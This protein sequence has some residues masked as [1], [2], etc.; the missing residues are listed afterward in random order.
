MPISLW[1][2]SHLRSS[3]PRNVLS[4]AVAASLVL[5]GCVVQ[6]V[7][8]VN[9]TVYVAPPPSYP[10]L[11]YATSPAPQRAVVS[12]YFEPPVD[13]PPPVL[14][15]WAPPPML[16]EPPSPQ[17]YP[18]A[19][20]TGGYW[21]W[22]GDWVWAAGRWSAPPRPGYHW[23]HPYY[24]HRD[25][26]VVFVSGFWASASVGFS[27]PGLDIRLTIARPLPGVVPGPPCNGPQGVF[28]PPPPGS[29]TGLIVPAPVGTPP[30]VVVSAP[31][32][33]NVGMRV[34]NNVVNNQVTN[35]TNV[36]NVTNVTVVAPAGTTASG[37]A[38]TANVP[39]QAHLAASIP[40]VTHVQAPKPMSTQAIPAFVAGR[41]QVALPAAQQ[42]RVLPSAVP[43]QLPESSGPRTQQP[44]APTV[45]PA[46]V[47]AAQPIRGNP[48]GD[49]REA[50][51][52]SGEARRSQDIQRHQQELQRSKET[53]PRAQEDQPRTLPKTSQEDE[54]LNNQQM[55]A[56]RD[57][58]QKIQQQRAD[59]D[60]QQKA[61]QV[62][63]QQ[64]AEQKTQ[65]LKA[66]RETQQKAQQLNAQQE[67]QQKAQQERER[68]Q[69][70]KEKEKEKAREE[71][72]PR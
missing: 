8:R 16:V 58:Q 61:Q 15:T 71:E 41:A 20:W 47:P 19:V 50:D 30:A 72:R 57:A 62:K 26:G 52:V 23:V 64:K 48:T 11:G 67:A 24:E 7:E 49:A 53:P 36:T 42:V 37:Q 21:T 54:H 59:Q 5:G 12:A 38:Y 9:R 18:E 22:A 56:Q 32:I 35:I 55:K 28:I 39:S 46:V 2:F 33:I 69:K 27:A 13:Q 70:E 14:V 60:A 29:R 10:T 31:P 45:A 34:Q 1:N 66:Q 68:A 4:A 51:R 63:A 44:G 25:A 17:P 6:P 65:Q 43:T 3:A 40:A